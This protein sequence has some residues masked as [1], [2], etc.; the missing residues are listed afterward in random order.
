METQWMN[1][2]L[3]GLASGSFGVVVCVVAAMAYDLRK[4]R[5]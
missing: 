5:Q 2:F 1:G 3:W 4:F